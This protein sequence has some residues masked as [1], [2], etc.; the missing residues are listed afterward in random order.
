MSEP[1]TGR[2]RTDEI[3]RRLAPFLEPRREIRFAV[4]HGSV[5]DRADAHDVDV[6]V[7][8]EMP[9]LDP[10]EAESALSI[11]LSRE[12]GLQIDVQILNGAPIGVLHQ[13]FRGRLMFARNETEVTDLIERVAEEALQFSHHLRDYLEA[14]TT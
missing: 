13:V 11:A 7:W 8:L 6:A 14:V 12:S 3:V 2:N 10:F 4:L 5:L 9:S 1:S